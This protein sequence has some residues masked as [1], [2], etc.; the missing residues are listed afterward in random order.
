MYQED[1]IW[2]FLCT[3]KVIK[4]GLWSGSYLKQLAI[5]EVGSPIIDGI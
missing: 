2:V 4:A 3:V 5:V 1:K